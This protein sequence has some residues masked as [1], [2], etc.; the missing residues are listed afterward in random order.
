MN[1]LTVT[2]L[3]LAVSCGTAFADPQGELKDGV[4]TITVAEGADVTLN[5]DDVGSLGSSVKLVKTGEGRLIIATNM[6]AWSGDFDIVAGYVRLSA[7]YADGKEKTGTLTLTP[8]ATIELGGDAVGQ[9][10]SLLR[11]NKIYIGGTGVDGKGAVYAVGKSQNQIFR[12][13]TTYLTANTLF[14]CSP[15]MGPRAGTFLLQGHTLTADGGTLEICGDTLK[16]PGEIHGINGCKIYL[17]NSTSAIMEGTSEN[18]TIRIDSGA[19]LMQGPQNMWQKNRCGWKICIDATSTLEATPGMTSTTLTTQPIGYDGPVEIAQGATATLKLS[20]SSGSPSTY[21]FRGQ[22]SGEG[23]L[24]TAG[25]G[26]INLFYPTNTFGGSFSLGGEA[27]VNVFGVNAIPAV[28]RGDASF[29]G[30]RLYYDLANEPLDDEDLWLLWKG[31]SDCQKPWPAKKD[32]KFSDAVVIEPG[33][34]YVFTQSLS[35]DE[36]VVIPHSGTNRLTIAS[37]LNGNQN[38]VNF[39]GELVFAGMEGGQNAG[40]IDVRGGTVTVPEGACLRAEKSACVTVAADYPQT[41]RFV[42]KGTYVTD[43]AGNA[44]PA[45]GG[46]YPG[47]NFWH[48]TAKSR[49]IVEIFDGA[50]VTNRVDGG[51]SATTPTH[52]LIDSGVKTT[53]ASFFQHGGTF[54]VPGGYVYFGSYHNMYYSLEGGLFRLSSNNCRMGR[55]AGVSSLID[56]KGGTFRCVSGIGAGQAGAQATICVS[57]TGTLSAQ[58]AA[59]DFPRQDTEA[60]T[61]GSHAI[62]TVDGP[63]ALAAVSNTYYSAISLAGQYNAIG[64]VNLN[65]GGTFAGNGF[66]KSLKHKGQEDLTNNRARIGF[67]GGVLKAISRFNDSPYL[68]RDFAAGTDHVHIYEE[69]ATIDTDGKDFALGA[70]LEAPFGKGV[71]AIPLPQEIADLAAFEYIAAPAVEIV[72]PDGTGSNATAV[73]LYDTTTGKVTGFRVMNRGNGYTRAVAK[74]T[75]GGYTNSYEIACTLTPNVSGGFTKAGTGVLTVDHVCSYTGR[76][77]LAGGTLKLGVDK[78]LRAES[79][80]VLAG[81]TLDMNGLTLSDGSSGVTDWGVDLALAR[82]NGTAEYDNLAFDQGST[83]LVENADQLPE[84]GVD[85]DFRKLVLM[86]VKGTLVNPPTP[87]FAQPVTKGW[88]VRWIGNKLKAVRDR[89]VMLILR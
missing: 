69:G 89:G 5:S 87:T 63:H 75:K 7:S 13:G 16:G 71:E 9:N 26:I 17:E 80:F 40:W 33:R 27:T 57:G 74:V 24:A 56:I 12:D 49:G 76:T 14:K 60:K 15:T 77:V 88:S 2:A 78:A 8:G 86:D 52:N 50:L 64:E 85:E 30:G 34:P 82:A 45:R 39:G 47:R 83:L 48:A 11:R 68:F 72:D 1:K 73:A 37:E 53:Q 25:K 62:F 20:P 32:E 19:S 44:D 81:G 10:L 46:I 21:D 4:Y 51:D 38:F 43:V 35:G 42:V 54:I 22:F 79:R 59:L 28:Q 3:A 23:S 41:A 65:H 66:G 61:G 18:S 36:A 70:A 6:S 55:R 84:E 67:N 31:W 58:N 29:A